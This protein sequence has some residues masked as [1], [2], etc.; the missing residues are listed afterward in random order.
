MRRSLD[1]CLCCRLSQSLVFLPVPN[2]CSA[3]SNFLPASS[4]VIEVQHLL[5]F[6]IYRMAIGSCIRFQRTAIQTCGEHSSS[7]KAPATSN[8]DGSEADS[9]AA[10]RLGTTSTWHPVG[11][12]IPGRGTRPTARA[13]ER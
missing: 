7:C 1:Q 5:G 10:L 4:L 9:D 13:R 6:D 12:F 2:P 11:D 8:C 3:S